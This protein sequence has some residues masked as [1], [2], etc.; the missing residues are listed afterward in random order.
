[1]SSK[2]T[3]ESPNESAVKVSG[4]RSCASR[5]CTIADLDE[6]EPGKGS[7]MKGQ[8]RT[9]NQIF[10]GDNQEESMSPR[11]SPVIGSD[12]LKVI[13]QITMPPTSMASIGRLVLVL[14]AHNTPK[15]P[16]IMALIVPILLLTCA[17][18]NVVVPPL[19]IEVALAYYFKS[20]AVE[21]IFNNAAV[22]LLLYVLLFTITTA[23]EKYKNTKKTPQKRAFRQT[24]SMKI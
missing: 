10:G 17:V 19:M 5:G 18:V 4:A 21:D 6:L 22:D 14:C 1:M 13:H 15:I 8:S 2:I 16:A 9:A 11:R 24:N 7:G 12:V 3:P 23:G 20:I